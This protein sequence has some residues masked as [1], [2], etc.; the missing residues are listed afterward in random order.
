M[1]SKNDRQQLDTLTRG[2]WT[3]RVERDEEERFIARVEEIPDAIATGATE[4]ELML[5]LWDAIETSL[6][7]RIDHGDPLPAPTSAGNV[8]SARRRE[9]RF[10]QERTSPAWRVR[11]A[12][13]SGVTTT[14][15]AGPS[16]VSF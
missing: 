8:V 16:A 13:S 12:L 3:I 10:R 4:R 11:P 15:G 6:L 1:T 14:V 2:P 5:D 7:A 9:I